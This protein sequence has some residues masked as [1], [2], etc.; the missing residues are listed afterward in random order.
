MQY[1]QLL[2]Y[3]KKNKNVVLDEEETEAMEMLTDAL[4]K[5]S[6][7]QGFKVQQLLNSMDKVDYSKYS[8]EVL[9]RQN[10]STAVLSKKE[11]E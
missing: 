2:N 10:G 1:Y 5:S 4:V 3:D 11:K 6:H 9:W 8:E 7:F